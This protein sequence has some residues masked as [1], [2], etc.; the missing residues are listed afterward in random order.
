MKELSNKERVPSRIYYYLLEW[1]EKDN[2]QYMSEVIKKDRLY[3]CNKHQI[4]ELFFHA[5]K[6]DISIYNSKCKPIGE[7]LY[8]EEEML[9]FAW[10]LHAN[11]GKTTNDELAHFKDKF[12]LK[13]WKNN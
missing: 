13:E 10:Y 7:N 5:S 2:K 1:N 11:I 12:Y 4:Y 6:T 3:D 9:E 8:T